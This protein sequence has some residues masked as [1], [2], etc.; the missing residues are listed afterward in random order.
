[1]ADPEVMIAAGLGCRAGC[2]VGQILEVLEQAL[3]AAGRQLE[4]LQ[5]LYTVDAKRGEVCLVEAAERL[6]KPLVL[7]PVEQLRAQTERALTRSAHT[8]ERFGV[9]SVAE[10]AALAGASGGRGAPARLLGPRRI[11]G[12]ATCALASAE[13]DAEPAQ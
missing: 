13:Q 7:L 5:A 12:G 11:W 9:P 8:L 2:A 3:A 1:M 6:K 4:D 10:T